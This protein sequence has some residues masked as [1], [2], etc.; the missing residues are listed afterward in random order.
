MHCA[1]DYSFRQIE[2]NAEV[3]HRYLIDEAAYQALISEFGDRSPLHVSDEYARAAGFA[4]RVMHGAILQGFLSHFVGMRFPGRKSLILSVSLNYHRPSYFGD[5]VDLT[6]RVSRK[7]E[8]G[9]VVVLEVRFT[10]AASG[11]LVASGKAQ[12]AVRDG[13]STDEQ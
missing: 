13:K 8:I 3:S 7:V 9:Q 10:N 6:A 4:G 2:E 11:A 5:V 12:V 1:T